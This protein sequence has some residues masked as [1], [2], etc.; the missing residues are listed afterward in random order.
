MVHTNTHASGSSVINDVCR[1]YSKSSF[2]Y[3]LRIASYLV[4]IIKR[5]VA[6]I[7]HQQ[8]HHH[9]QHHNHDDLHLN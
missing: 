8:H 2:K 5:R 6:Q 7:V 1:S 9:H 4:L 3:E